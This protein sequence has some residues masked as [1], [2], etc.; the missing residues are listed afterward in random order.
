[1]ES[2]AAA[3]PLRVRVADRGKGANQS[4]G[5]RIVQICTGTMRFW[6]V[7][8]FCHL[9]ESVTYRFQKTLK[10]STPTGFRQLSY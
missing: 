1:M 9:K 10:G 8:P 3:Y 6:Q 4:A 7:Y 2:R 5:N